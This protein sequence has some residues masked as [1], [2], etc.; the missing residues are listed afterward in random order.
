MRF[1]RDT[2][3]YWHNRAEEARTIA[4]TMSDPEARQILLEIAECYGRLAK[5]AA[6]REGGLEV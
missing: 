5:S 3:E 6:D 1:L 2:P 4:E